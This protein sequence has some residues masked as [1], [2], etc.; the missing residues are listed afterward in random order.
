[1]AWLKGKLKVILK[2]KKKKKELKVVVRTIETGRHVTHP[3]HS[4]HLNFKLLGQ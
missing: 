3:H 4:V 1:M 2:K